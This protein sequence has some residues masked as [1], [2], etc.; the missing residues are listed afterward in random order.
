MATTKVLV[1]VTSFSC[2]VDGAE[3]IIREGDRVA[4]TDPV[5]KGRE[6]LFETPKATTA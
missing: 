2:E 4:A 5:V 6:R 3:R 1:A